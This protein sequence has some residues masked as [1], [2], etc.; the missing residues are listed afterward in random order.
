MKYF[1]LMTFCFCGIANLYSQK[2]DTVKKVSKASKK[3]IYG[4]A[5]RA[6]IMSAVFPGL[7]QIYNRK[8]WKA[9]IIYAGLGGFG[10]ML[11]TNQQQYDFYSANLRYSTSTDPATVA[12]NTTGYS[13]DQLYTLKIQY[14]KYRDIGIIGCAIIYLV[15]IIDA[16]VDA[17]LKTFDVSDNLSM[18]I[19]PFSN[20][21]QT[22]TGMSMQ[23]GLSIQLNF[24]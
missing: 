7:G 5:R 3:A 11:V 12:K 6:T 22:G 20:F 4:P 17:H 24:K 19:K 1:F 15:N 14:R 13:T 21:A 10:Y 18:R 9:P 16:N 23:S 8:Y 2:Q